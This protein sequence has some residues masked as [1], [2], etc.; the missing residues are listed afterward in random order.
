METAGEK[1]SL[2]QGF[3]AANSWWWCCCV[4]L[5][6]VSRSDTDSTVSL[7]R[8][9]LALKDLNGNTV[10]FAVPIELNFLGG[11]YVERK[12]L[13]HPNPRSLG[14]LKDHSQDLE[15]Y[16]VI[17]GALAECVELTVALYS[18]TP[19]TKKLSIPLRWKFTPFWWRKAGKGEGSGRKTQVACVLK[20]LRGLS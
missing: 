4:E 6:E 9:S 1:W 16:L 10:R 11:L 14:A 3:H 5:A 15:L 19:N 20:L 7:W 8:S 17:N 12:S 2:W 18:N 13:M